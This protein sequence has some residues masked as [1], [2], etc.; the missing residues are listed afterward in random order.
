MLADIDHRDRCADGNAGK[1]DADS[2]RRLIALGTRRH[3]HRVGAADLRAGVDMRELLAIVVDGDDLRA[4]REEPTTLPAP[5]LALDVCDEFRVNRDIVARVGACRDRRRA[6]VSVNLA[7]D[8]D[9]R[10]RA[11]NADRADCRAAREGIQLNNFLR[12]H[13]DAVAHRDDRAVANVGR[14]AGLCCRFEGSLRVAAFG[15]VCVADLLRRIVHCQALLRLPIRRTRSGARPEQQLM[16]GACRDSF[17]ES[18]CSA[19]FGVILRRRELQIVVVDSNDV[20]RVLVLEPTDIVAIGVVVGHRVAG[21][22]PMRAAEVNLVIHRNC[23][24]VDIVS[25]GGP[26]LRAAQRA[27]EPARLLVGVRGGGGHAAGL[28]DRMLVAAR[29]ALV[30]CQ[31]DASR[32]VFLRIGK[33]QL[34]S[35]CVA[36]DRH[37]SIV[38]AVADRVV[39]LA[40]DQSADVAATV[41]VVVH[42]RVAGLEAVVVA[43]CDFV[44]ADIARC[45]ED[46]A[47]CREGVG[48]LVGLG[49]AAVVALRD[50]VR[51]FDR[52]A[53]RPHRH[54]PGR[55]DAATGCGDG[56]GI[57]IAVRQSI[58]IH[59]RA[60]ADLS[61]VADVGGGV[62]AHHADVHAAA[63]AHEAYRDTAG[64]GERL[65]VVDRRDV[66]R[67]A[68]IRRGGETVVAASSRAGQV[69]GG[70]ARRRRE[71]DIAA[72][73]AGDII[74]G[75]A[76]QAAD[77]LAAAIVVDHRV[78]HAHAMSRTEVDRVGGGVDNRGRHVV[79]RSGGDE[80]VIAAGPGAR[81]VDRRATRRRRKLDVVAGDAR[82]E[83]DV[84]ADQSADVLTAAI[85]VDQCIADD[86]AVS[87]AHVD[88]I[89]ERIHRSDGAWI[90]VGFRRLIDV[91]V[92]ADVSGGVR[93][94]ERHGDAAREAEIHPA[95][96]RRGDGEQVFLGSGLHRHATECVVLDEVA[97]VL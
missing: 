86:Q 96:R 5:G 62:V 26:G 67:L 53:N 85:V 23:G 3:R 12:A 71:L 70:T 63:D 6:D 82:D 78:A 54:R 74:G 33:T 50:V 49:V 59:A 69:D 94:D 92:G 77:I 13:P 45:F 36:A 56:D 83:V 68:G 25:A 10:H 73:H 55:G 51:R 87:G 22:E 44:A 19:G 84:A 28:G 31:R 52:I 2:L 39:R 18:Y 35:R 81:Q 21:L 4:K 97:V 66:D 91:G 95:A 43:E 58:D 9:D 37:R 75:A 14:G 20:I 1:L 17:V 60:R 76:D 42:H 46:D 93:V 64:E 65:E 8:V 29:N 11:A 47:A 79:R 32:C 61:V 88:G 15:F 89:G 34:V 41:P 48:G 16:R 90:E 38:G 27:G 30:Q 7:A 24:G 40:V 72:V 80:A 57:D